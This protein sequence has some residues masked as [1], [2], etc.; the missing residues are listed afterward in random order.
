MSIQES[1]SQTAPE[2]QFPSSCY[3]DLV[4]AFRWQ[5]PERFNIGVDVCDRWARRD[6]TRPALID[7]GDGNSEREISFGALRDY[8]NRLANVLAETGIG[9]GD[10]VAIL[11]PQRWE[12][13]AAHI[14]L[15]KLGVIAVPL[16]VLFGPDALETRLSD[17]GCRAV[18][19]DIALADTIACL[20]ARLPGL[21]LCFT[22]DGKGPDSVDLDQVCQAASAQFEPVA[23]KA[24]DPAMIIYTSGTTGPPKGT[25]HAHRVLLGHLPGMEMAFDLF[26][27]PGDRMWSPADWSWIGGLLVVLLPALHHGVPVVARRGGPLTGAA[28]F[29]IL[30]RHRIRNALLPPAALRLMRTVASPEKRWTLCLRSVTAGGESLTPDLF[31]WAERA[32]GL[33][34]NESYG[35]TECNLTIAGCEALGT[36]QAGWMGRRTPGH[37]VAIIDDMGGELAPG[38]IGTIAVHRSDPGL[39]LGYWNNPEA[40][41]VKFIGDW[42][43]TGDIGVQDQAGRFRFLGRA[44]D[45]ITSAGHRIGPGEIETCLAGHPAVR[46]AAVVGVPDPLRGQSIKA[47]I[48]PSHNAVADERLK[49]ALM[50]HVRHRLAPHL[51]PRKIAFVDALPMTVT[52]KIQRRRLRIL[53]D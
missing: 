50:A 45:I 14:A 31:H 30:A 25:V 51:C 13:A 28:L 27:Q 39:F 33:T 49:C 6:P 37:R 26:P 35:Q 5:I 15:H 12:T 16:S 43:V 1:L 42:M 18:I 22:L 29:D 48:A 11:L 53:G 10:R 44:D 9:T 23:T 36:A 4:A 3:D 38:E 17:S 20:Q 52:G 7:I 47:F 34:V 32:L 8:S 46:Q 2:P 41:R 19:T 24:D 40:T 21:N